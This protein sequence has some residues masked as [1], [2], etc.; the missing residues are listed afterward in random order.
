ME[1]SRK[2]FYILIFVHS[3]F[4]TSLKESDS[5]KGIKKIMKSPVQSYPHGETRDSEQ[6]IPSK[7]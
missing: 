3:F 5:M 6:A 1:R 4:Y 2:L 7:N